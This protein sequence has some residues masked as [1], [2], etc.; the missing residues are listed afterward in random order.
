MSDLIRGDF[1]IL[2][3]CNSRLMVKLQGDAEAWAR[4]LLWIDFTEAKTTKPIPH[5]DA[6]LL[7]HEGSGILNWML[8][9]AVRLLAVLDAHEPFPMTG[10][11]RERV[12][13]LLSESD[14]ARKFIMTCVERSPFPLDCITS[15]E[16]FAGYLTFCDGRGW[17]PL[18]QRAFEMKA[19][20]LM[21]QVHR[22]GPTNKISRE[23]H[24][25]FQRG[26]QGVILKTA[27]AEGEERGNGEN[28]W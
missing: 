17:T 22:A 1:N 14:A 18:A 2:M 15:A 25:G 11:Q 10:E 12:N 24:N 6:W 9:G 5:F 16:L 3:T 23:G 20:D 27:E 8:E 7:R 4:R 26:Y 19:K 13:N 21:V 28:P